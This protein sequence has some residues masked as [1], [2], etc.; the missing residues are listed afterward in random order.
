MSLTLLSSGPAVPSAGLSPP[1][2]T[3]LPVVSY[4]SLTQGS[5]LTCSTGT[6]TGSPLSY[7]YQWYNSSTGIISGSTSSTYVTQSGDVGDDIYCAVTASNAAG[8]SSPANSAA[9]GPI[10]AVAPTIS[11]VTVQSGGT[12]VVVVLSATTTATGSSGFTVQI[13]GS[14]NLTSTI[15]SGSGTNTL[16]LALVGGTVLQ[17]DTITYSYNSSTG[18]WAGSGGA[19]VSVTNQVGINSSTSPSV[20]TF[21]GTGSGNWTAPRSGTVQS[22]CYGGGG[23]ASAGGGTGSF[24]A[25]GGGGGA[26]SLEGGITVSSG[27]VY[28]YVAPAGTTGAGGTSTF[29]SAPSCKAVG[30]AK[31]VVGSPGLGGASIIGVGTTKT[32]GGNGAS[33][34]AS[35]GG[36]G[37]SS[38]G[39]SSNGNNGINASGGAAPTGGFAGGNGGIANNP[40]SPGNSPG[41]GAGGGGLNAGPAQ[42]GGNAE[43]KIT[44]TG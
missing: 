16:T 37:G 39:T 43:V 28:P 41:G 29:G 8:S 4:S 23:G 38:G 25:S 30:G 31:G 10:T 14:D 24:G 35:N 11:S 34:V 13:D 2:N 22:E 18:N 17:G 36:G 27:S 9:V 7:A 1:T 6:W 44:Y 33:S 3:V 19:V 5:T 15:S 40:G 20:F 12:T 21:N 26:Y 32:S 42:V